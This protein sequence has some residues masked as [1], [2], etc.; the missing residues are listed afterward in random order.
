MPP[1]DGD[2]PVFIDSEKLRLRMTTT[3][4]LSRNF[5]NVRGVKPTS[6][7]HSVSHRVF[8]NDNQSLLARDKAIFQ[9]SDYQLQ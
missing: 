8:V 7:Y 1:N 6:L 5:G 3:V 4:I 9:T 2:N